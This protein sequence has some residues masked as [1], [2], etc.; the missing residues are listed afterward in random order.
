MS[1][2]ACWATNRID[3]DIAKVSFGYNSRFDLSWAQLSLEGLKIM[4]RYDFKYE[5][6]FHNDDWESMSWE[7]RYKKSPLRI[8]FDGLSK[9]DNNL[10]AIEW[11]KIIISENW[12]YKEPT[13]SITYECHDGG[14]ISS[15]ING[16]YTTNKYKYI[17]IPKDLPDRLEMQRIFDMQDEVSAHYSF[18]GGSCSSPE[19]AK[20]VDLYLGGD[21]R[22]RFYYNFKFAKFYPEVCFESSEEVNWNTIE[23][24]KDLCIKFAANYFG[25]MYSF[26]SDYKT[27]DEIVSIVG[28]EDC[29]DRV[30]V[31]IRD[32]TCAN[33]GIK[34]MFDKTVYKKVS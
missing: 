24:I 31:Y 5:H 30:F 11:Y 13:Y 10:K 21:S 15:D 33:S 1:K 6:N 2:T 32:K 9:K 3:V 20:S 14:I 22:F 29:Q 19:S 8:S 12:K 18:F 26:K 34:V 23:E 7:Q 27:E 4:T 28:V 17:G 25:K 16:N